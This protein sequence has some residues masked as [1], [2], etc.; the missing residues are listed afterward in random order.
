MG[1]AD[2]G[3]EIMGVGRDLRTAREAIGKQIKDAAQ[4]LRIGAYH[5]EALEAGRYGDLPEPVYV[6]GFVR[7][8]AG[9][10][11]L[12]ADEMV[13]RVRLE[14]LPPIL[15]GGLHFPAAP[16]DTPGPSRKLLV[17]TLL[18]AFGIGGLWYL[19]TRSVSDAPP[20]MTAPR[21]QSGPAAE[22]ATTNETVAAETSPARA[23]DSKT[24]SA[25]ED[26]APQIPPVDELV[27]NGVAAPGI[28]AAT[29]ESA[30]PA[31]AASAPS[32]KTA[33]GS[34]VDESVSGEDSAILAEEIGSPEITHQP[35]PPPSQPAVP[36]QAIE[37][38]ASPPLLDKAAGVPAVPAQNGT[39]TPLPGAAAVEP[40]EKVGLNQPASAGGIAH[41]PVVLRASSDTW[42]QITY[43]NGVVLKSW[44]MR[45]G[46]QYVP[47][48]GQAGLVAL[49]G[50]AGALTVFIDGAEMPPLGAKGA[51]VRAVP[52]DAGNLKSRFGG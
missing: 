35:V 47:P 29:A 51:V 19:N 3:M 42:M 17:L 40:A 24:S 50:N 27:G 5:L 2:E 20:E 49:I 48:A 46:E 16:Q 23:L 32:E 8:Y 44:V 18:L 45:A 12:D 36:E 13:R 37:L 21:A 14:L 9:Y 22:T 33:D 4:A 52:L 7:N 31:P 15:P 41:A 25:A 11:K 38:P 30:R 34:S 28:P 6:Y 43:A 10:L 26:A 1:E 39:E